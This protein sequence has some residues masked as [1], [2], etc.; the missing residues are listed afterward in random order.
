MTGFRVQTNPG[1]SAG[2]RLL[3]ARAAG[4]F[5]NLVQAA[6]ACGISATQLTLLELGAE[7]NLPCQVWLDLADLYNVSVRWLLFGDCAMRL[8]EAL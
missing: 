1:P 4:G 2:Q 7:L 6:K 3:T 5:N 8:P